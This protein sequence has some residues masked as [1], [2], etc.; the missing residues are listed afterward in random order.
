MACPGVTWICAHLVPRIHDDAEDPM[1]PLRRRLSRRL[2]PLLA[3]LACRSDGAAAPSDVLPARHFRMGFSAI[4]PKASQQ[5]LLDALALWTARADAAIMHISV[6]YGVMLDGTSADTY[7]ETVDLPLAN[8]FR[9]KHLPIVVT[10]DVTNG[11]DRSAEAPDLVA[12]G[13]SITDPAVQQLYRAYVTAF[14]T[15]VRPEYLGLAAETNLIREVGPASVYAAIVAMTNAAAADV[16]RL[17]GTR[18]VLF[19]SVQADIA[20]G[21]IIHGDV[22][23]GVETDFRDFPFIAALGISSYPYFTYRDPDEVPLDYYARLTNGRSLPVM[24]VEGGWTSVSIGGG[25]SDEATQARYLRRQERMLD[26]ARAVATFQLTFTDLDVTSLGLGD[27]AA[28]APFA[29]LGLVD[30]ELRPKRALATYDSVFA[31]R[32]R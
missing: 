31:R 10:L 18:P 23:Q 1:P 21:R 12:H 6:P 30:T 24:V 14:A 15:K 8:Y 17:G 27:A 3:A 11:L 25:V 28:L 2:L 9:A 16:G 19:V 22:Y 20:W 29:H 13:R 4:P 7:V 32:L 26:S 5:S